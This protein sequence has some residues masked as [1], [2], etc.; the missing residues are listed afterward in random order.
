MI[1]S[2]VMIRKERYLEDK[3]LCFD[4]KFMRRDGARKKESCRRVVSSREKGRE[5]NEELGTRDEEQRT[6][7][8]GVKNRCLS[9]LGRRSHDH[10]KNH[11]TPQS[12]LFL[13]FTSLVGRDHLS[14]GPF[15]RWTASQR[16]KES[17][18]SHTAGENCYHT[19]SDENQDADDAVV[20]TTK[21]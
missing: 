18:C 11:T 7:K 2:E 21:H 14:S 9:R 12:W 13:A 19:M 8:K 17:R 15:A 20:S 6:R 4:G 16:V 10:E 3:S 1:S 5:K